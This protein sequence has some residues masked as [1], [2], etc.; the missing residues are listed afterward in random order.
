MIS[1]RLSTLK[2]CDE[3]YYIEK[4][5]FK[6]NDTLENLKNKYPEIENNKKKVYEKQNK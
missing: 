5:V 3:I 2:I 6:D 1:H 4:G